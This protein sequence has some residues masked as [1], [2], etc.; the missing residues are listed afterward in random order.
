MLAKSDMLQI[1][2]D[3]LASSNSL[4]LRIPLYHAKIS[5][6]GLAKFGPSY[7]MMVIPM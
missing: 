5:D 4:Q 7:H 6:F 3:R 1:L 2:V